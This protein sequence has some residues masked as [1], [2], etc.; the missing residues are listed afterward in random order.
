M[1]NLYDFPSAIEADSAQVA[2]ISTWNGENDLI[3]SEILPND[4]IPTIDNNFTISNQSNSNNNIVSNPQKRIK[5]NQIFQTVKKKEIVKTIFL[6][7][8]QKLKKV[9]LLFEAYIPSM[10]KMN[11][12]YNPKKIDT[13]QFIPIFPRKIAQIYLSLDSD[14]NFYSMCSSSSCIIHPKQIQFI[15]EKFWP[16]ENFEFGDIVY[17]FFQKKNNSNCRFYHKLYN[18]LQITKYYPE[19]V[20]LIGVQWLTNEVIQVN[21]KEFARLLGIRTIDG[22]LFHRQGNFPSHGF[23]EL[24]KDEVMRMIPEENAREINYS[25]IKAIRHRTGGFTKDSTESDF[26]HCNWVKSTDI[27]PINTTDNKR[28]DEIPPADTF[29]FSPIKTKYL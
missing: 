27:A 25:D 13:N 21:S 29:L 9:P 7:T 23:V 14:E 8:P 10:G 12:V 19:F 3:I 24:T 6:K 15:P 17:S 5:V 26:E 2:D 22:S 11:I 16:N 20:H 28:I 1:D 4:P 18:A